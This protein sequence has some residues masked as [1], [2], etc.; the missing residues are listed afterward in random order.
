MVSGKAGSIEIIAQSAIHSFLIPH[1]SLLITKY[2]LWYG[3][4][5][6][7]VSVISRSM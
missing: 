5:R 3:L 1:S 2:Y 7:Y 4:Y 6:L